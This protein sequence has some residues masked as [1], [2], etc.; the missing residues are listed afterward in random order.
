MRLRIPLWF[1]ILVPL[2]L[3]IALTV[4]VSGYRVYLESV[5]HW[6][7]E[8]DTRAEHVAGLV[9][10]SV[11]PELLQQVR[12]PADTEGAVFKQV[13]RPLQDA[14][15]ASNLDWIG[16]YYRDDAGH[17]YYWVDTSSTGV[18]YPFFYA[19]PEHLAA[20]EDLQPHR[21]V[22]TDE[23]GSY[24]GYVAPVIVEGPAGPRAVAIVEASTEGEQ[25]Q[26]LEQE[27]LRRV[28]P[29]LVG[30]ALLAVMV[31][32]AITAWTFHR[33]LRRLQRGAQALSRG[34]LGYTI[35]LRSRDE[36]GDLAAAFDQM[37]VRLAEQYR[38][39]QDYSRLLEERVAARTAEL[40]AE[41]N[42]LDAI[43]QNMADGLVVTDAAGRIVLVNPALAQMFPP[44]SGQVV[45]GDIEHVL[46][47]PELRELVQAAG[48]HPGEVRTATLSMP[49]PA[50][51]FKASA[52]ALARRDPAGPEEVQGVVTVLRDITR[53]AE[54]DRMKTDF[55]SMV[56]HELRTPLTS[57]LGFAK[58]IWRSM[59]RDVVPRLAAD[60][61]RGQQAA[62]R[63]GENLEII[64]SEGERLTRL[65]NDVL[66]I[67]KME[68][69]KVEWHMAGVSIAEVIASATAVA[70]PLAAGKGLELRSAVE[71][72]L[73]AVWA[74]RDR[75]EQV[76]DNLLSNAVK[77]TD[78][79]WIEV[80]ARQVEVAADGSATPAL[81]RAAPPLRPGTWLAVSVQ[82][83]GIGIP[84]EKAAAVFEKFRQLSNG[85]AGRPKGTGLGLAICKEIVEHHGGRIWVEST[86]GVGS[87]FTFVLP[88]AAGQAVVAEELCQRVAETLPG[89][90]PGSRILVVDDEP[91]IRRLLEL[92][93][94]AAG[95]QVLLAAN[96]ME[97]LR[98]TRQERPDLIVLDMMMPGMSGFDLLRVFKSDPETAAIPV[99]IISVLA[100]R[101]K[102]LRLGAEEYLTKPLDTGR[103]LGTISGLLARARGGRG[104]K[105]VLVIDEDASVIATISR[106]LQE[107]GY[108]VVEALDG[109]T[110][111]ERARRERPDFIILDE[112]LSKSDDYRLLK[113]LKTDPQAHEA[114]VIV[115]AATAAPDDLKR[116][117]EQGT[118]GEPLDG[119]VSS[120]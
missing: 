80:C 91:P 114:C 32:I 115:L 29:T 59:E 49:A 92:E 34:E 94:S 110:A 63:I 75:L 61:T 44:I 25:A 18:G 38:A 39:L 81:G 47:L 58:L 23:F 112:I 33:P 83:S 35:G 88:L 22:Y 27:T 40:L 104:G 85:Q 78:T 82:D 120:S 42:R 96:G 1:K 60:D 45:G 105:K 67:A 119:H 68:A 14:L 13:V 84:P 24:R 16:L 7:V 36:L 56:S 108:E 11:D 2:I 100:D 89:A 116:L 64:I 86:P 109:A 73:A 118:E 101:E 87:T 65:I 98:R 62:Q 41:R 52:C 21:V 50:R 8:L 17:L 43:L 77:F 66:D 51:V 111:L 46:P 9:A 72:G 5:E 97:A 106:V 31:A 76:L 107:Q 103:L 55:I 117:L 79:G 48:A 74:D 26:L 6:Q 19:T 57:V 93:L 53:E 20:F 99:L 28:L 71:E 30:G 10:A 15:T 95:Y 69:G 54:V 37:S 4:G 12:L 102:G 113:A 90:R 70:A 3:L